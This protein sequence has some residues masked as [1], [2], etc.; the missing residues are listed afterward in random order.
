[1]GA[2]GAGRLSTPDL[3]LM[4]DTGPKGV[5]WSGL[6]GDD[7]LGGPGT[8]RGCR[9]SAKCLELAVAPVQDPQRIHGVNG[10]SSLQVARR[11]VA[12][13]RRQAGAAQCESECP[14]CPTCTTHHGSKPSTRT[15]TLDPRRGTASLCTIR[16]VCQCAGGR[17][18]VQ[19]DRARTSQQGSTSKDGRTH[20]S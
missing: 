10:I 11:A 4:A 15:G 17:R 2:Q 20:V 1:M 5:S 7:A 6:C 14:C 19:G 18:A 13:A 16:S 3:C 9:R 12:I 8:G